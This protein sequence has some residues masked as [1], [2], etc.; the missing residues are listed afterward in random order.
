MSYSRGTIT[1]HTVGSLATPRWQDGVPIG[2]TA[3][4]PVCHITNECGFDA[5]GQLQWAPMSDHCRHF[6]GL[7]ESGRPLAPQALFGGER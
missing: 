7:Y 5:A 3:E 4:C 6:R 1:R 2:F